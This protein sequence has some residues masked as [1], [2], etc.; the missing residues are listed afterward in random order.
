[1][2]EAFTSIPQ[3]YLFSRFDVDTSLSATLSSSS[4]S[5][6]TIKGFGAG[7]GAGGASGGGGASDMWVMPGRELQEGGARRGGGKAGGNSSAEVRT[8]TFLYELLWCWMCS[9]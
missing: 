7:A 9:L 1:V 4:S 8:V 6:G 5:G 2:Q 3:E